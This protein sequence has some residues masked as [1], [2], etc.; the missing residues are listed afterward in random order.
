[1]LRSLNFFFCWFNQ[2][3]V[4]SEAPKHKDQPPLSF[5]LLLNPELAASALERGPAADS[6][7][8]TA[9]LSPLCTRGNVLLVL[10]SV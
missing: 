8:V 1:M 7:T 5:G 3:P 2:W 6:T 4:E 9:P 10:P